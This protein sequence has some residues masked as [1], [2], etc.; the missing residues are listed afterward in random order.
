MY[1]QCNSACPLHFATFLPPCHPNR[2]LAIRCLCLSFPNDSVRVSPGRRYTRYSHEILSST[3]MSLSR[4]SRVAI[5]SAARLAARSSAPRLASQQRTLAT[6]SD[7]NVNPVRH[8]GGLKDQD[9]IFSYVVAFDRGSTRLLC[10][11]R[12]QTADCVLLGYRNCYQQRDHGI[13][14]AMVSGNVAPTADSDGA[15][16]AACDWSVA[17]STASSSYYGRRI[18]EI[19]DIIRPAPNTWMRL[20]VGGL[21]F[22]WKRAVILVEIG[23]DAATATTAICHSK[24]PQFSGNLSLYFGPKA[25]LFA[26]FGCIRLFSE[27]R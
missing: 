27:T 13:K 15:T 23:A 21:G 12:R 11:G 22:R 6:V 16:F 1:P 8:Y 9:R 4:S 14:G 20:D 24:L 2:V 26:A 17:H 10:I 3:A 19:L 25:N 7:S 5:R 18:E